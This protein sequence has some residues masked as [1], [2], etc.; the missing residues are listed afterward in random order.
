M[1]RLARL[2]AALLTL[3]LTLLALAALPAAAADLSDQDK[4]DVARV[5]A[6]LGGIKTLSGRFLQVGPDGAASEGKVWLRRPGRVRFEY[7]PPVPVLVV[8]DGTFLI[9]HDKEL[10]QI[11]RIPLGATPLSYILREDVKL[12][13]GLT[14]KNVER[15]TGVLRIT[16]FDTAKPREGE[17]T[18]TFSEGPL[19]LR[20]W[21]VLDAR[22]QAT[23]ITLH[24]VATNDELPG[25]LFVFID[26]APK[27]RANG[28]R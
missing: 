6:Y 25:R 14:V 18:L 22:G 20:Q 23:N 7:D 19:Q 10:G 21:T 15:Q 8:G 3:T 13:G 16:V 12:S 24:D 27:D 28:G 9:F 1:T 2:C 11:D 17:L 26:P 4:A 5:E